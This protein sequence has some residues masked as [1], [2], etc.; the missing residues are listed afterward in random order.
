MGFPSF[1]YGP[2]GTS[3]IFDCEED[4][5]EGWEDHPS[6]VLPSNPFDHD[7]DGKP[8]GSKPGPRRKKAVKNGSAQ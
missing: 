7:G 2:G 6:K 8:G 5:P 1:R 3:A 4:V